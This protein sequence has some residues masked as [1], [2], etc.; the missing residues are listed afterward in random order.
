MRATTTLAEAFD[1]ALDTV[2]CMIREAPEA[3][4]VRGLMDVFYKGERKVVT[5]ALLLVAAVLSALVL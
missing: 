4:G 3:R 1:T 2:G 5:G